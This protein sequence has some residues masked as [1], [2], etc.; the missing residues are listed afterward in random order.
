MQ[1]PGYAKAGRWSTDAKPLMNVRL[2]SFLPK[3]TIKLLSSRRKP[4]LSNSLHL[5][6]SLAVCQSPRSSKQ[7]KLTT[8]HERFHQTLMRTT[9]SCF[10][11]CGIWAALT[12][13]QYPRQ[14]GRAQCGERMSQDV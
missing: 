3:I 5:I 7:P 12:G 9:T 14:T 2:L 1:S 4:K 8:L 11:G 6:C 10:G 13:L